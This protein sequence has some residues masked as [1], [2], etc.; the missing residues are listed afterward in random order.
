MYRGVRKQLAPSKMLG[1]MLTTLVVLCAVA[2]M[3]CPRLRLH[4]QPCAPAIELRRG[5]DV[6]EDQ[7]ML[8]LPD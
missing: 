6:H 7:A 1:L 8:S 4:L 3:V 2:G 5:H